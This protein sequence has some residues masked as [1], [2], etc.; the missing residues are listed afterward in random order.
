MRTNSDGQLEFEFD[1]LVPKTRKIETG[2]DTG[3]DFMN[4]FSTNIDEEYQYSQNSMAIHGDCISVLKKMKTQSVQLIFADAPYNIGK[5]F[6]NSI[7]IGARYGWTSA[8]GFCQ[9][10]GQCIL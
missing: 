2:Q 3:F 10:R 4:L 9:T 8:C 1:E 6:G 7:L 5:D